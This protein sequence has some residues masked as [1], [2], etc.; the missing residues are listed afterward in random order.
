MAKKKSNFL[1]VKGKAGAPHVSR[2][3]IGAPP[4]L[5]VLPPAE[6]KN[7]KNGHKLNENGARLVAY[8]KSM[9]HS[10]GSVAKHLKVTRTAIKA[11]YASLRKQSANQPVPAPVSPQKKRTPYLLKRVRETMRHAQKQNHALTAKKVHQQLNTRASL[12][13]VQR[14]LAEHYP[15]KALGRR[16]PLTPEHKE[17]R[18]EFDRVAHDA[19]DDMKN[20]V[21]VDETMIEVG[22]EQRK[23]HQVQTMEPVT[24]T[25]FKNP[26]K[27]MFFGAICA[28]F[29]KKRPPLYAFVDPITTN[30]GPK[31]KHRNK[32]YK[33]T[34]CNSNTYI[35][36]VLEPMVKF[37]KHNYAGLLKEP[38]FRWVQDNA[39]AHGKQAQEFLKKHNIPVMDWPPNSPDFNPIERVWAIL[40]QKLKAFYCDDKVIARCNVSRL[41]WRATREWNQLP[42]QTV[43]HLIMDRLPKVLA[44]AQQTGFETV[45]RLP[46]DRTPRKRG[47]S[48]E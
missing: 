15:V 12:S 33:K 40:K 36:T 26:L 3:T 8:L 5:P 45:S 41:R 28:K 31:P 43:R 37:L 47:R 13:T 20:W 25:D 6:L 27:V 22:S 4:P 39:P 48:E 14:I 44:E 34:K 21:F 19:G 17:K 16:C 1:K 24:K 30:K 42:Q 35:A 18:A 46:N 32:R 7:Y 10:P 38:G 23:A 9:G 2:G 11:R 29:D